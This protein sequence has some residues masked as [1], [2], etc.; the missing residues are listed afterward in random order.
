MSIHF[1]ISYTESC[2]NLEHIPGNSHPRRGA[3]TSQ[4]QS[5][6]FINANQT[7]VHFIGLGKETRVPGGNP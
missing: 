1:S 2:G 4:A 7:T 6:Q 3:N 5:G